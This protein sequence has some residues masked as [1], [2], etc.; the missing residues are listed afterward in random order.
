V[1]DGVP[2]EEIGALSR[3]NPQGRGSINTAQGQHTL[4]P[5]ARSWRYLT[6]P[7]RAAD[8]AWPTAISTATGKMQST[9][10]WRRGV[11]NTL[12]AL[13]TNERG[14]VK[15]IAI[16]GYHG[17]HGHQRC[18]FTDDEFPVL[19]DCTVLS[20]DAGK[21]RVPFGKIRCTAFSDARSKRLSHIVFRCGW[22][23]RSPPSCSGHIKTQIRCQVPQEY[24]VFERQKAIIETDDRKA[25][26]P[27]DETY[28]AWF[29]P[30]GPIASIEQVA[31]AMDTRTG[32]SGTLRP[33][34][35]AGR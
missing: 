1:Y 6:S 15:N 7:G 28:D 23:D 21:H 19:T 16:L 27:A 3:R 18:N 2:I 5:T 35:E 13:T 4:S 30:R 26:I 33:T 29:L 20:Q 11:T 14:P 24:I 25:E 31:T 34:D 9:E 22:L 10:R 12:G 32:P 17:G 8:C